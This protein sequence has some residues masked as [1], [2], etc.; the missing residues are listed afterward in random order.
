MTE[1]LKILS[2]SAHPTLARLIAQNLGTELCA[3]E[4][5]TFPDGETFSSKSTRTSAGATFSSFSRPA[6]RR[7]RT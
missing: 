5:T 2:G 6:R 1:S 4:L 3:A 7:I